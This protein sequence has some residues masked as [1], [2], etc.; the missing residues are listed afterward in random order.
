MDD[1]TID[2]DVAQRFCDRFDVLLK[3]HI[4]TRHF[5]LRHKDAEWMT[6]DIRTNQRKRDRLHNKA[7]RLNAPETWN[8]YRPPEMRSTV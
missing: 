2:V 7:K 6:S 5:Y 3:R 8:A 4:P 1:T